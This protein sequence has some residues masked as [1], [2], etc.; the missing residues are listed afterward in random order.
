MNNIFR[1]V[2]TVLIL[3]MLILSSLLAG[4]VDSSDLPSDIKQAAID[5]V[6]GNNQKVISYE[7]AEL[8]ENGDEV[9]CVTVQT[10]YILNG[11]QSIKEAVVRVVRSEDQITA[12][13]LTHMGSGKPLYYG[14][15][16]PYEGLTDLEKCQTGAPGYTR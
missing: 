7:Q 16:D 5:L 15:T 8:S 13:R 4:C 11:V 14:E 1:I 12:E 9:W 10:K 6:P 3:S 2:S